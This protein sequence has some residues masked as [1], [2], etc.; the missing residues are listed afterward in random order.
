MQEQ[1]STNGPEI[2]YLSLDILEFEWHQSAMKD[3]QML[4]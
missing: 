4:K 2:E 1:S 3:I